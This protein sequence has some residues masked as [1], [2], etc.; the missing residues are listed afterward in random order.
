MADA[1]RW[2]NGGIGPLFAMNFGNEAIEGLCTK[3]RVYID[4]KFRA[5]AV[6]LRNDGDE[7]EDV[8]FNLY[9]CFL[10]ERVLLATSINPPVISNLLK[11]L[12]LEI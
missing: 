12:G 7:A 10:R 4:R 3:Q 6:D 1:W 5:A 8:W 11:K 2:G 9:A